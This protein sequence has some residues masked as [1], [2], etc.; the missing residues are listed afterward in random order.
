[1]PSRAKPVRTGRRSAIG[2]K[3]DDCGYRRRQ[4]GS[5]AAVCGLAADLL[6]ERPD[7]SCV[8][9]D[10][11]CVRC[12]RSFTPSRSRLNPVVAS[13]VYGRAARAASTS[14]SDD[15]RRRFEALAETAQAELGVSFEVGPE[16]GPAPSAVEGPGRLGLLVPPPTSRH[17]RVRRWAVGVTT[18]PRTLPTLEVCLESLA[19]A[20][21]ESP[22]LFIDGPAPVPGPFEAL[23]R[24]VHEP[25]MGA[26]PTYL[27]AL[28]ELLM[29]EPWA[30]A[31]L[32]VQDDAR[33]FDRGPLRPYLERCLWPGGSTCLVSLYCCAKDTAATDGW[34][35]PRGVVQSGP[36]ALVYPREV[37]KAF[38]TSPSVFRRRWSSD[39]KAA[40][41]I[42]GAIT[43]WASA[44]G[45]PIWL[46]TPSLA[47]HIGETSTLWPGLRALGPRRAA[48]FAGD[49][50]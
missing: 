2:A 37:A 49:E 39:A 41:T 33:F 27:L 44:A 10:D 20:G 50:Y 11:L 38:V 1:M 3:P 30:D 16:I 23:P 18:A 34:Q 4:P 7:I 17:G 40:A 14:T 22:R 15:E 13:L 48:R 8:V 29:R 19:R 43:S 5:A 6:S 21:W 36:V 32:L 28:N 35:A 12:L 24:T 45:V 25:Q 31:Y 46:P 42:G 26:W 9:G 47:Q